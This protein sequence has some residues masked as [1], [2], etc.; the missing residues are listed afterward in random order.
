MLEQFLLGL[1][2]TAIYMLA[3]SQ[4]LSAMVAAAING[5][6]PVSSP[7]HFL[8][9]QTSFEPIGQILLSLQKRTS[10]EN[11]IV[12]NVVLSKEGDKMNQK[13]YPF[14]NSFIIFLWNLFFRIP[15]LFSKS[16]FHFLKYLS[17]NCTQYQPFFSS[18][19]QNN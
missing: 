10:T 2:L 16:C 3:S 9:Q 5:V 1:F 17:N 6:I 19:N 12:A 8:F 7:F 18:L 11:K 15:L 4:P 14:V 13:F